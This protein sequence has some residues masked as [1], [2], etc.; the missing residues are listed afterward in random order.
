MNLPK[1]QGRLGQWR[2][3]SFLSNWLPVFAVYDDPAGDLAAAAQ[4]VGA[5]G[6]HPTPFIPWHQ[7]FYNEAGIYR[8]RL[9]MPC[10]QEVA[11]TGA[12]VAEDGDNWS[13]PAL[14]QIPVPASRQ[15]SGNSEAPPAGASR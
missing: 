10:G 12:V 11:C 1:K 8:V 2:D 5:E 15:L 7:P 3:V 6:W 14:P 9:V 4:A 13:R